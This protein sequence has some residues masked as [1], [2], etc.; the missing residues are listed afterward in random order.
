MWEKTALRHVFIFESTVLR[1]ENI[2]VY[3]YILGY[4][5]YGEFRNMLFYSTTKYYPFIIYLHL[6]N[7][8]IIKSHCSTYHNELLFVLAEG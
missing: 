5:L 1:L 3:N 4:L 8:L 7:Q 2:K 6:Q